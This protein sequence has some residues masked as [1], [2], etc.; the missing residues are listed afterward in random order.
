[1]VVFGGKLTIVYIRGVAS[2]GRVFNDRH[3]AKS[4]VIVIVSMSLAVAPGAGLMI[5]G[6]IKRRS[7][8]DRRPVARGAIRP[9]IERRTGK[10]EQR[11]QADKEQLRGGQSRV[12]IDASIGDAREP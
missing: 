2:P 5:R 12:T 7:S 3:S 6:E 10:N 8:L 9:A 11:Q 1:V 4:V